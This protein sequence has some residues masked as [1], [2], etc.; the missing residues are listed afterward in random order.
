M[1]ELVLSLR[2]IVKRFAQNTVLD[3]VELS[4]RAGEVHAL[5]GENGA[6]KSTLMKI[7][8]GIYQKD[9]GE[10][11]MDGNPLHCDC[12]KKALC[13]GIAMIHQELNPILDMSIAENIFTGRELRKGPFKL[14]DKKAMES[15]ADELLK[16][17][18]LKV[19]SK[20]TMRGLSIAQIQL[21]EIV[22]ATSQ[23]A[24]V[25]IMDEPTS[26]LTEKEVLVLFD[27][28]KQLKSQGV[29]II[30]ISHKLEE[31][32]EITDRITVLRDGKFIGE[33]ETA[34]ATNDQLISMMVGREIKEVFP[35]SHVDI[36]D[37]ALEVR[38]ICYSSKVDNVSFSVHKGEILGIAGLV[39]AGR[40]ETASAL[41][42]VIPKKCG[43]I[44]VNGKEVEIKTPKDA[45]RHKIAYVTEDRK[46]TGLNLVASICDNT[47]IVSIKQLTKH[48]LLNRK[49]EI[50]VADEYIEKL[51]VKTDSRNKQVQLLSGGNQ[52]KVAISKWLVGDPDIIIL[53]EPTR[54]IDVGAKRDIYLLMGELVKMGKAIIMISSEMPEILGMSDRIVVLADGKVTGEVERADFDQERIMRMQFAQ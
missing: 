36:G 45:V 42:G 13:S 19:P 49:N 6:G 52:Q 38:D 35:K 4:I 14:V 43:K 51:K 21:V 54:G 5:M 26:A 48:R 9:E 47:T 20:T 23:N 29:A 46:V 8:M 16:T 41:F 33:L 40:S 37:V 50:K 2:G 10:I 31:V 24:K 39:G 44:L 17:V 12:P 1:E 25:I 18:N 32:F 3:H 34:K 53:D 22:K 7:L 30:F 27:V 15:S 28:I 11:L